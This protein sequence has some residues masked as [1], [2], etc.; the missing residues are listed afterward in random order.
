MVPA[1]GWLYRRLEAISASTWKAA[2]A[3]IRASRLADLTTSATSTTY[4][5]RVDNPAGTGRDVR[6]VALDGRQQPGGAVP[7]VDDGKH[8]E[9]RV[10]LG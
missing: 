8:H 5:V 6:S 9:V 3:S 10:E 1:G 7:L 2:L 4:R